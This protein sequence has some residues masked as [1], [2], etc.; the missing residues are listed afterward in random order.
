MKMLFEVLRWEEIIEV[1]SHT[2]Y[3]LNNNYTAY[4]ARVLMHHWPLTFGGMFDVRKQA[5]DFDPST[6]EV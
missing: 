2:D 6:I 4:Y 1:R 3:K 5:R